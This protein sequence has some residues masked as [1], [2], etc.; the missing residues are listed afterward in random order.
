MQKR[1]L[2]WLRNEMHVFWLC[3]GRE[4][5]DEVCLDT[6]VSVCNETTEKKRKKEG[7]YL[8]K[9]NRRNKPT[10]PGPTQPAALPSLHLSQS[11]LSF[12]FP[13]FFY[14]SYHWL[15]NKKHFPVTLSNQGSIL[16]QND[17]DCVGRK[18]CS[19]FFYLTIIYF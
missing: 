1:K 7:K 18:F 16:N 10:L 19:Y 8:K 5:V 13:L 15:N 17:F 2:P 4:N 11:Q 6:K 3:C 14:K 12:Q 9:T